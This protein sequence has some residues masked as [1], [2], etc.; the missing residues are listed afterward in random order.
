[1]KTCKLII[2]DYSTSTVH[3]HKVDSSVE[4]NEEYISNIGYNTGN[5]AWMYGDHIDT[6]KHKSILK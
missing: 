4:I 2:L 1:M 3:F 6:F 5:C